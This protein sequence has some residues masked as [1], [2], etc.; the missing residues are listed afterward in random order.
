MIQQPVDAF[1][2]F[3]SASVASNS[4]QAAAT[5]ADANAAVEL[6]RKEEEIAALKAAAAEA[7]E[8]E[9]VKAAENEKILKEEVAGLQ[10]QL[11][12]A[13]ALQEAAPAD[14]DMAMAVTE[15]DE[16]KTKLTQASTYIDELKR[17]RDDAKRDKEAALADALAKEKRSAD[18]V[19]KVGDSEMANNADSTDKIEGSAS[20]RLSKEELS[21]VALAKDN[22]TEKKIAEKVI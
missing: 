6:M 20:T 15:L 19:A 16:L 12:Q 2:D 7:L 1:G 18:E 22:A 13:P 11:V 5:T 10:A 14:G 17:E 4:E 8:A 21:K 9:K 3:V